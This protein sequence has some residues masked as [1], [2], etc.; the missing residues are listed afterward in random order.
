LPGGIFIEKP[1]DVA[2][3]GAPESGRNDR[4]SFVEIVT[5]PDARSELSAG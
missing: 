1:A 2:I 4:Q 5:N 3:M